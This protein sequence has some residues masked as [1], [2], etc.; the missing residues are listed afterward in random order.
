MYRSSIRIALAAAIASV[1]SAG[2]ETQAAGQPK[3]V[4]KP[5]NCVNTSGPFDKWLAI[6]KAEAIQKGVRKETVAFALDGIQVRLDLPRLLGQRVE[7]DDD[8]L[9]FGQWRKPDLLIEKPV[10]LDPHAICGA[11]TGGLAQLDERR[12]AN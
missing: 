2:G 3:F 12:R 6:F 9:L 1:F 10:F 5:N 11:F 4:A 7:A 8:G